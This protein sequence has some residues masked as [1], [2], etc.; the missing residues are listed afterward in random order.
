M[1][2]LTR[3][4]KPNEIFHARN[5]LLDTIEQKIAYFE[6]ASKIALHARDLTKN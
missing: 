2:P 5:A 1:Q 6:K 3:D 4:L